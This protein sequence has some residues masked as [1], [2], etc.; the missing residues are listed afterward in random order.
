MS[1]LIVGEIIIYVL[2]GSISGLMTLTHFRYDFDIIFIQCARHIWI[3]ILLNACDMVF[4]PK[5]PHCNTGNF[6]GARS[7]QHSAGYLKTIT[8]CL[9]TQH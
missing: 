4:L 2:K 7:N 3:P 1:E 5:F 9:A 6:V 8:S